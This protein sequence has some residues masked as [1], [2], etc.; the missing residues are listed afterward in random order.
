MRKLFDSWGG[1]GRWALVQDRKRLGGVGGRFFWLAALIVAVSLVCLVV[2]AWS[3]QAAEGPVPGNATGAMT[4]DAV[5]AGEAARFT[6]V[7]RAVKAVA[8]AVVNITTDTVVEREVNPFGGL[9]PN[10]ALSPFMREFFGGQGFKQTFKRQS[11]GSGVIIDGEKGLVLTNAHV[12][13][14]ATAIHTRLM[15]GR[16]FAAELVGADPDFDLAV[17]RLDKAEALPQVAMADSAGLMIG[18]TVIAIGNPYGFTHTVTTG[19]VSALG[20]T[21]RTEQ[22]VF[23]DFIQTDA[24]INPG[25]SGGPLLDI[26]GRLVGV[27]TAIQ[28]NAEGIGFAIPINK[29]KRVVDELLDRGS[30]SPVWLG[31]AGQNLDQRAASYL[32]LDAVRGLLVTEVYDDTPAAGAGVRPGDVVLA[33]NGVAIEDKDH[34][35]QVVRN[36]VRGETVALELLREGRA[37]RVSVTP[38]V[39]SATLARD[40]ARTRWG[41]EFERVDGNDGGVRVSSVRSGSP[42]D[43]LGI[44]ARDTILKIGGL[45]VSSEADFVHAVMRYRMNTNLLLV[46]GRAGRAYYV[47]MRI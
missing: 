28:A 45:D 17:L 6:P 42:A 46:V 7:V 37:R 16:E 31:L 39:F 2:A 13:T 43:R 21:V 27:N 29:A 26:L 18:E 15:D 23:T 25:N 34:Y 10:E 44:A 32:G 22:G 9:F 24:A 38:V 11:L 8:P 5:P 20:R 36:Y 33:V 30:V 19:V 41:L 3:A 12:I 47:R 1:D 14:G 4:G 40:L 35:L